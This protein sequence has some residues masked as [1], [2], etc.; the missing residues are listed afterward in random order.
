MTNSL[1]MHSCSKYARVSNCFIIKVEFMTDDRSDD[2]SDDYDFD[3]N[4]SKTLKVDI[5]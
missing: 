3:L 2:R 4:Y 5:K 1:F